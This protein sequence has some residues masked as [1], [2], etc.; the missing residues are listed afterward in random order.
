MNLRASSSARAGDAD[1]FRQCRRLE[2]DPQSPFGKSGGWQALSVWVNEAVEHQAD[3][4]EGDHGFGDLR[5]FPVVLGQTSP[6][7]EPA[8]RSFNNPSVRDH[9]EAGRPGNA[10]DDDQR[11]AEEEAG[12][13]DSD[14]VVDVVGEHGLEPAIELLDLLQQIPGAVGIL[15]IGGVDD[16]AQEQSHT[17]D[18]D[19]A[20]AALHLLGG[21]VAMRLP[22]P[23]S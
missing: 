7:T 16:H 10:A 13:Q 15:D 14:P 12:E 11:Q 20:L 5:Q 22:F 17:V 3:H 2:R 4:G 21:I 9:D 1:Q 8:E 19:M 18:R 6:S 23:W